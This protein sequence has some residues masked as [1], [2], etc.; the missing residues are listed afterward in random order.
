MSD[1]ISKYSDVKIINKNIEYDLHRLIL[2]KIP[3]FDNLFRNQFSD[4]NEYI[5]ETNIDDEL[6]RE[7]IRRIYKEYEE[8]KIPEKSL[9]SIN[10]SENYEEDIEKYESSK[11]LGMTQLSNIIIEKIL[12]I[13]IKDKDINRKLRGA[14]LVMSRFRITNKD[15]VETEN[16]QLDEIFLVRR[17]VFHFIKNIKLYIDY[18]IYY[19]FLL[20]YLY[21]YG[22]Y[23]RNFSK[24]IRDTFTNSPDQYLLELLQFYINI[25]T[26]IDNTFELDIFLSQLY[27]IENL[28]LTLNQDIVEDIFGKILSIMDPENSYEFKQYLIKNSIPRR[29][30]I[31]IIYEESIYPEIVDYFVKNLD[32]DNELLSYL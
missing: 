1:D 4:S 16:K 5:I 28:K 18:L 24:T 15:L 9:L 20:S 23:D 3:F 8:M 21:Y 19:P 30:A 12:D 17:M 27:L 32:S 6:F 26:D 14:E 13:W 7:I 10:I 11:Y 22:M 29:L 2:R 31:F 25:P